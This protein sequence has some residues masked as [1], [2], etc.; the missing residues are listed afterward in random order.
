MTEML[1][2]DIKAE[3]PE[4][5]R[6]LVDTIEAYR[7][8]HGSEPAPLESVFP[9]DE[10]SSVRSGLL[11]TGV[12]QSVG[13]DGQTVTMVADI[14][15]GKVFN[16]AAAIPRTPGKAENFLRQVRDFTASTLQKSDRIDLFHRIYRGEGLVNN[17]INKAASLIATD[18]D[19]KIHAIRGKRGRGQNSNARALEFYEVLKH[20]KTHVNARA[21]D[22]VI[23]GA[24]GVKS[25][26]T[27][28]V[29]QALIEGDSIHRTIWD[30]YDVPALGK[31][32][33]LP[34]NIMTFSSKFIEV[35]KEL[36]T[37]NAEVL[38]WKPPREFIRSLTE[39]KD[40]VKK[41]LD[42]LIPSDVRAALIKDGEYI[43]DQALLIHVKHRGIG[44]EVFG[45]SMIEPAMTDIAYK[46]ALQALDV[47]T[48][49]NLINRLVII[50]VGSDDVKSAYHKPEG[51]RE[52]L[53]L[54]QRM[55][56]NVGPASTILWAGPD[57]DVVE[58]SA[59]NK[60]LETDER[61]AAADRR[62]RQALGIPAVLLTGEGSD[63]KAAGWAA[64]VGLAAQ[65]RDLQEQFA[66]TMTQIAERI[67]VEN[68]FED[69]Q[70]SWEFYEDLLINK[71]EVVNKILKEYQ[72]GLISVTTALE[73]LDHDPDVEIGRMEDDVAA[74]Y[75]DE[76]FGPP[77]GAVTT[78][79]AGAIGGGSGRP[80]KKPDGNTDPRKKKEKKTPKENK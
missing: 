28:G 6:N 76:A 56:Q 19:F 72:L 8:L 7:A 11:S 65:L 30:T 29:R 12:S 27:Q 26:V 77:K 14:R 51:A 40:H 22:S 79:P 47:V 2:P 13:R 46:R 31:A 42:K 48:I 61:Y 54:L 16:V 45:E 5:L 57:I 32:Y 9:G 75:R 50:K 59:H 43:L 20:F 66:N 24:R 17:A 34:M 63:G 78:D 4:S 52:R 67:A 23:Q 38:V 25:F 74:G 1:P 55:F 68:G 3:Q 70:V 62:I 49:E 33:S 39:G 10:Y 44:V 21:L 18:G 71:E 36:E 64:I 53:A 41:T 80:T 73:E 35:P 58:V 15:D 37:V 60:I 69:V